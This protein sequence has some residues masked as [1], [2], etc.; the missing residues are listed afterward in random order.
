MDL[1]KASSGKDSALA[2]ALLRATLGLN[3]FMHGLSRI[4]VGPPVFAAT[5]DKMFQQTLLSGWPVHVFGLVLPWIEAGLGL[6]L[7][8]GLKTRMALIG[9]ALLIVLLTFGTSL[10]QDWAIAGTQLIYAALYAALLAF[11]SWDHYSIDAIFARS[12]NQD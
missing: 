4:L 2:Y 10:R 6:L 8:L 7:L 9:G 5:L 12:G 1:G 3:I 11:R